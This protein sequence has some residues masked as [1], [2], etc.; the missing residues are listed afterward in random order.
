MGMAQGTSLFMSIPLLKALTEYYEVMDEAAEDPT[1]VV[2]SELDFIL[3]PQNDIES[4]IWVLTYVIMSLR[5]SVK[6]RYK[7]NVVDQI[8]GSLSY[9]GLAEKRD[10]MVYRGSN[11]LAKEPGK[12]IPNPTQCHGLDA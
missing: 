12:W 7:R 10:V 1:I 6:A 2:L 4:M 5:G 9:S 3:G 8:Y 11:L